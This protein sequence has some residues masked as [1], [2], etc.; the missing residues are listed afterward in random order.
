MP[1]TRNRL[2]DEFSKLITDAAGVAEGARR[3]VE[4]F[5]RTQLERLLAGMDLVSRDEF[6]AVREM[7]ALARSDNEKL[8]A[9]VAAL[10]ARLAKDEAQRTQEP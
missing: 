5:G 2:F 1:Q 3:E 4:T 8:E 7:A 9:R 10:E 6:E